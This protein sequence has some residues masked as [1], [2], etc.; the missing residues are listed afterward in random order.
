MRNE[1]KPLSCKTDQVFF[2]RGQKGL[3]TPAERGR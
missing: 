2:S 1:G 3:N